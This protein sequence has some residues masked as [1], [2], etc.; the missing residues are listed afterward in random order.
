MGL[1]TKEK[2]LKDLRTDQQRQLGDSYLSSL[3]R[4]IS[5]YTPGQAAPFNLTTNLTDYENQ[6]LAS[7]AKYGS[8]SVRDNDVY[9]A[10][11]N[12]L[13]STL[14][15][16]YLDPTKNPKLGA[17]Q[18]ELDRQRQRAIDDAR[19]SSAVRGDFKSL[20]SQ[21]VEGDILTDYANRNATLLADLYSQER[22]NQLGLL[23]TAFS[24]GQTEA[25][26]PLAQAQ[27]LTSLGSLPRLVEETNIARQL[28]DFTRQRQ[29]QLTALNAAGSASNQGQPLLGVDTVKQTTGLGQLA[30]IA[31]PIAGFFAGGPAGA[32]IG[33]SIA[34]GLTG[35]QSNL[36]QLILN[37]NRGL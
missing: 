5:G 33:S 18:L 17:Y 19:R 2:K 20:G 34:G 30:Q 22:Q 7:L 14:A 24:I 25:N 12:T 9:G 15:G 4:G 8:S 31:A 16:E 28:Q 6:G 11:R 13:L 10:G 36:A 21:R 29:E 32:A 27:A 37:Q 23:P 35:Q 1:F 3:D 26:E